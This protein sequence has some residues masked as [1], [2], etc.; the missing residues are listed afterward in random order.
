MYMPLIPAAWPTSPEDVEAMEKI[1][2]DS[3]KHFDDFV[4]DIFDEL[5][6]HGPIEDLQI[7]E[8]TGGAPFPV[9]CSLSPLIKQQQKTFK[10]YI[11]SVFATNSSFGRECLRQV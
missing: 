6:N 7:C 8:N 9:L 4:E 2:R 10:A 3:Q 1:K 5:R 11:M